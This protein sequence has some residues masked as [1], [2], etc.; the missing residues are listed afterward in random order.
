MTLPALQ[1]F[2]PGSRQTK[3]NSY[4]R[5][6][7]HMST[8]LKLAACAA[9]LSLSLGSM[10]A[11]ADDHAYTEGPVVN[12]SWIRTA[13]GKFDDYVKW[14]DTVWKPMQEA[15]IKAGYVLSYQVLTGEPR[16]PDEPDIYLIITYKNWAALDDGV[17]KADA[18]SKQFEG[19]VE[20]ANRSFA[21]RGR[22]RRNIGSETLQELKLK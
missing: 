18:L 6:V 12:M 10:T 3:K 11:I 9:L 21:D 1:D 2:A 5:K 8:K 14:L 7:K 17:A 19:S 22:I 13:D 4:S 16:G 15:A 20:A